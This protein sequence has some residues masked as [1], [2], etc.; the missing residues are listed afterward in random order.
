MPLP[1]PCFLVGLPVFSTVH[2]C[3]KH[4]YRVCLCVGDGEA[5]GWRGKLGWGALQSLQDDPFWDVLERG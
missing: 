5:G 1:S 3:V 4:V 2:E